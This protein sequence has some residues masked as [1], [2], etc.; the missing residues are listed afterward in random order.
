MWRDGEPTIQAAGGLYGRIYDKEIGRSDAAHRVVWRRVYGP[1]PRGSNGKPLEVDHLCNVMLCQRPDHL[2]LVTK[3]E[4]TRRRQMLSAAVVDHG[5][6][7]FGVDGLA[8]LGDD[9]RVGWDTE[10]AA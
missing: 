10:V 3:R 1:I 8:V 9:G 4:N 5:S 6:A 7:G 2:E